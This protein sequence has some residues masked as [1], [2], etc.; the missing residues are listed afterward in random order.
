MPAL[1]CPDELPE[2]VRD[3]VDYQKQDVAHELRPRRRR[4]DCRDHPRAPSPGA[5]G[6]SAASAVGAGLARRQQACWRSAGWARTSELMTNGTKLSFA[7]RTPSRQPRKRLRHG[8]ASTDVAKGTEQRM[9]R[10]AT[11]IAIAPLRGGGR[12]GGDLD[13][14]GAGLTRTA[15]ER[16][17]AI[18]SRGPRLECRVEHRSVLC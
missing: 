13:I 15:A 14:D 2:D 18:R 17:P 10:H 7:S 16:R 3:L 12:R 9:G 6:R 5:E 8:V 1:P 11:K 4:A